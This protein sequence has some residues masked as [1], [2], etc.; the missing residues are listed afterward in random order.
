MFENLYLFFGKL[1]DSTKSLNRK[2][3]NISSNKNKNLFKV[4]KE[5]KFK[6]SYEFIKVKDINTLQKSYIKDK[7][8]SEYAFSFLYGTKNLPLVYYILVQKRCYFTE[9]FQ[10]ANDNKNDSID[11]NTKDNSNTV[12]NPPNKNYRCF[13][14]P[15]TE[16]KYAKNT[17]NTLLSTLFKHITKKKESYVKKNVEIVV[18]PKREITSQRTRKNSSKKSPGF[19]YDT[20][21][22]KRVLLTKK[23]NSLNIKFSKQYTDS[24]V[25]FAKTVH[26]Y[27]LVDLDVKKFNDFIRGNKGSLEYEID[28]QFIGDENY[29]EILEE[30]KRNNMSNKTYSY[31]NKKNYNLYDRDDLYDNLYDSDDLYDSEKK[32]K[33][34]VLKYFII[35]ISVSS[36][37]LL[38]V[39]IIIILLKIKIRNRNKISDI[40]L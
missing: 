21:S 12:N 9:P 30:V 17:K 34:T 5:T 27:I 33:R 24:S 18:F 1:F 14:K 26:K 31:K 39:F 38:F 10:Q 8:V 32:R 29:I 36:G 7:N 16:Y 40:K 15:V 6:I 25:N 3:S 13:F 37:L 20:V 19:N 28:A 35:F 22:F 23:D 4:S 11:L 2:V